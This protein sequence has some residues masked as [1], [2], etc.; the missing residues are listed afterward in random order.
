MVYL[1]SFWDCRDTCTDINL[2]QSRIAHLQA[3]VERLLPDCKRYTT[4]GKE[5]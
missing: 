3:E 5:R 1:V 4:K 2:E